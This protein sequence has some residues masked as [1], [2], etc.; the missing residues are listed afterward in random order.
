MDAAVGKGEDRMGVLRDDARFLP[1][2]KDTGVLLFAFQPGELARKS[3]PQVAGHLEFEQ[4]AAGFGVADLAF[5]L[6]EVAKVGRQAIADFSD[7]RHV[8][9]HAERRNAGG[10]AGERARL[11]PR[12]V[13]VRERITSADRDVDGTLLEEFFDGH[14]ICS[15]VV[16]C[17]RYYVQLNKQTESN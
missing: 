11:S 9:H 6:A 8:D 12:V 15:R 3:L 5:E 17:T 10:P 2:V 7:H 4:K 16:A 14:S 13:P 1:D